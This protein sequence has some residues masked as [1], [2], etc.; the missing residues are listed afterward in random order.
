MSLVPRAGAIRDTRGTIR[1]VADADTNEVLGVTMVGANASE[2]IHEAAMAMHFHAK[3]ADF[4]E[5][6]HVYPTMAEAMKIAAIART[7]DPAK[8]SCC[9]E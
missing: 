8:L 9:A 5:L 2:V 7:K 3:L 6:L 4:V 1:M